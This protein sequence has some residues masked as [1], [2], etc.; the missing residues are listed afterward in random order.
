MQHLQRWGSNLDVEAS[1]APVSSLLHPQISL[2]RKEKH[3]GLQSRQTEEFPQPLP[4]WGQ[5]IINHR[6]KNPVLSQFWSYFLSTCLRKGPQTMCVLLVFVCWRSFMHQYKEKH[7]TPHPNTAETPALQSLWVTLD[8]QWPQ[9]SASSLYTQSIFPLLL[10]DIMTYRGKMGLLNTLRRD[11]STKGGWL[12][13]S[14]QLEVL[15]TQTLK[16]WKRYTLIWTT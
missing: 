7:T 5:I 14:V 2:H 1:S 3:N 11:K 15:L 8:S 12:H 16:F 4:L 6:L 10:L 9:W 13:P